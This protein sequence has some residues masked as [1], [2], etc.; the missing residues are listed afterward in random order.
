VIHAVGPKAHEN[1]NRQVYFG[2][3]QRTVVCCLK[4]AEHVLNATSIAVLAISAGLFC[5]P[6]INVAQA[7]YQ[8]ILKF[9]ETKPKFVKTV[10]LVNL[11]KRVTDLINEVCLVVWWFGGHARVRLFEV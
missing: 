11:D 3:V 9:D 10:P 8:A 7:L 5:V 1:S 4:H 6:K 2:L